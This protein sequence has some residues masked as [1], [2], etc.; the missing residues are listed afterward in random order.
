MY[1]I[2]LKRSAEKKNGRRQHFVRISAPNGEKIFHTET[3][4]NLEDEKQM[5]GNFIRAVQRGQFRVTDDSGR[6]VT[7]EFILEYVE[8]ANK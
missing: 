1:Q 3:V 6:D 4:A 7:S 5:L 8:E 2:E